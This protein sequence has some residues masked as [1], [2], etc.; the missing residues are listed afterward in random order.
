MRFVKMIFI[1]A[2][3]LFIVITIISLFIPS[4]VRISK[5]INV[6]APANK[7][8]QPVQDLHQWKLWYP[9]LKEIPAN[10]VVFENTDRGQ[11]MKFK[12]TTVTILKS[13]PSQVLAE[14]SAQ[15]GKKIQSGFNAI[16][17]SHVDS[18]T[19]QWYMD[20]NLSWYPWEKFSSMLYE[21]MYGVTMERGL[22]NLK[23]IVEESRSS[24]K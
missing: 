22:T 2:L 17:Y 18:I 24:M 13:T 23:A 4:H 10:E 5:A 3:I 20:F 1:G 12:T 7:V 15:G 8:L 14:F 11:T 9:L 21:K 6:M 19:I 16:T